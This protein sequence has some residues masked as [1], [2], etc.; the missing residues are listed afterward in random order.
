MRQGSTAILTGKTDLDT[1]GDA[2][3]SALADAK[4]V[5]AVVARGKG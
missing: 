3:S 2:L 1:L 4:Q 5:V